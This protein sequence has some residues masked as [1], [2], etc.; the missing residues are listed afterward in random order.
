MEPMDIW[1]DPGWLTRCFMLIAL[2]AFF[3]TAGIVD[4]LA[5][6]GVSEIT[7][8]FVSMPFLTVAWFHFGGWVIDRRHGRRKQT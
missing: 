3:A 5:R 7:S 8:F 4:G 1:I 6:M 2:P